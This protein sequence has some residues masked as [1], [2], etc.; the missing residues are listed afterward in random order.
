MKKLGYLRVSTQEQRPDRQIDGLDGVCDE[1]F[2]EY[3][4]AAASHRP[5]FDHVLSKLVTRDTLVVLDLDRAFRSVVDAIRTAEDLKRRGISLQIA[6]LEV[7]METPAGRLV[8]A[9]MSACAAFERE[10]ISQ[11]TKE[12]LAAARRRG[13]RLGRPPRLSQSELVK[14]AHQIAIEGR[15]IKTVARNFNIHPWSLTRAIRR[16]ATM[17][18]EKDQHDLLR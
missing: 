8:F 13:K 10:L 1:L 11:R 16:N 5:V 9:V 15:S 7:D 4:S 14:A 2:V 3:A 12:G 6:S 17:P 18:K